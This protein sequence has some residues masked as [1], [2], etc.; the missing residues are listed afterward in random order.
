MPDLSQ[1][2][3][4]NVCQAW[5]SDRKEHPALSDACRLQRDLQRHRLLVACEVRRLN[6]RWLSDGI[7][8]THPPWSLLA[9]LLPCQLSAASYPPLPS[10][11]LKWISLT[12]F[13]TRCIQL[14]QRGRTSNE[15]NFIFLCERNMSALTHWYWCFTL[16]L[17]P[18]FAYVL[19]LS[20]PLLRF[21]TNLGT[22]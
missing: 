9:C 15:D 8:L 21:S 13:G 19:C 11:I 10:S 12:C 2:A 14:L 18:L 1:V 22:M 3:I 4:D 6:L 16:R 7:L 17:W 5:T 20:P